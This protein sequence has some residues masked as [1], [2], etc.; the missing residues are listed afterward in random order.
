ML[1]ELLLAVVITGIGICA[2]LPGLENGMGSASTSGSI[3]LSRLLA[4]SLRQFFLDLAFMDPDGLVQVSV[5]VERGGDV[6]REYRWL[7]ENR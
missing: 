3:E 7:V 4:E 5:A 6:M 2:M 1:L